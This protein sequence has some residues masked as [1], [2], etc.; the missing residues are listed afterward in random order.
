M[1]AKPMTRDE[2][3]KVLLERIHD[4]E[5]RIRFAQLAISELH[6]QKTTIP[7][8]EWDK[9]MT[10][11]ISAIKYFKRSHSECELLLRR[12]IM[13]PGNLELLKQPIP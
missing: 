10:S 9:R 3:M 4:M 1:G 8:D 5:D 12:L 13:E 7:A 6:K 2:M 11:L